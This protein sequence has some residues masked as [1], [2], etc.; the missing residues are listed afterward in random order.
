MD[1]SKEPAHVTRLRARLKL[2]HDDFYRRWPNGLMIS[3]KPPREEVFAFDKAIGYM[4]ALEDC[5][6]MLTND[7][8]TTRLLATPSNPFPHL[9][10]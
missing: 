2:L 9:A 8:P 7:E 5:I 4:E 3:D 1:E 10:P 6:E